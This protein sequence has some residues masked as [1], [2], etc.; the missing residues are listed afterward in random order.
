VFA[1]IVVAVDGSE[2][3]QQALDHA[4]R[5]ARQDHAVLTGVYAVDSR[6]DDFIGHD[7]QNTERARKDFLDYIQQEQERQAREARDQF[8]RAAQGLPGARFSLR[9]GDPA[10]VV[11]ELANASTTDLL[12]LSRRVFQ[13]SGRPSLKALARDLAK[14]ASRP[15]LLL[16]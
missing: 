9:Q 12:V 8:E 10:A 16:P 2:A 6:W 14:Q 7:W 1:H 11:L 15:L 4:V 3:S 13:V 5:L